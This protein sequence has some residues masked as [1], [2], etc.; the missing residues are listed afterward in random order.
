M[1]PVRRTN[2]Y[3]IAA[4]EVVEVLPYAPLEVWPGAPACV[5]GMFLYRGNPRP[6]VDLL[7]LARRASCP[8]LWNTRIIVVTPA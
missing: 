3:A 4:R 1:F 7:R 6:A 2:R 5:A 8:L